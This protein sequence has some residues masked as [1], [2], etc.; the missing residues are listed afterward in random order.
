MHFK[1]S[2]PDARLARERERERE[3]ESFVTIRERVSVYNWKVIDEFAVS[4]KP[5]TEDELV[6]EKLASCSNLIWSCTCLKIS[7]L[8]DA[9]VGTSP[10]AQ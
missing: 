8:N 10:I 9:R 4:A 6:K 2:H 5:K 1:E 3:R 7:R